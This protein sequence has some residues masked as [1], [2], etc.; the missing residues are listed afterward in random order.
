MNRCFAHLL[1]VKNIFFDIII[2]KWITNT[3]FIKRLI[4]FTLIGGST[5]LIIF[6][7]I[8]TI[9]LAIVNITLLIEK[10]PK[11]QKTTTMIKMDL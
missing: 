5:I 1:I 10:L 8:R 2:N 4:K 11:K 3:R 6:N 9:S 7:R